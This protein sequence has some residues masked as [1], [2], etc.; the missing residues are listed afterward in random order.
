MRSLLIFQN[1]FENY[2][3]TCK[4]GR[5]HIQIRDFKLFVH[6]HADKEEGR[7]IEVSS[8]KPTYYCMVETDSSY[9]FSAKVYLLGKSNVSFQ[10]LCS[11]MCRNHFTK[12]GRGL[13]KDVLGS[14]GSHLRKSINTNAVINCTVGQLPESIISI[15]TTTGIS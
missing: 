4:V 13:I 2:A 11:K 3:H 5:L 8:Q 6:D 1:I 10:K 9:L 14:L 15:F 7:I 12:H